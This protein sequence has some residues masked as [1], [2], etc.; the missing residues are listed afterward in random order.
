M[1]KMK[2][3]FLANLASWRFNFLAPWHNLRAA[4]CFPVRRV[5]TSLTEQYTRVSTSSTH[6]CPRA[7]TR[8]YGKRLSKIDEVCYLIKRKGEILLEFF[9]GQSGPVSLKMNRL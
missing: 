8:V 5:S 1:K 2:N 9:I 4:G 6:G 3:Q 7:V